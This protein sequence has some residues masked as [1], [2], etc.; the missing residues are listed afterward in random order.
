[1]T[2]R[3]EQLILK[4]AALA[5]AI[6]VI[7]AALWKVGQIVQMLADLP[8][9]ITELRKDVLYL[10]AISNDVDPLDRIRACEEYIKLGGNGTIKRLHGSLCEE[11]GTSHCQ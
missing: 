6:T 5:T 10:K 9:Q 3:L 4:V 11:Y 1:M 2:L 8:K 7:V